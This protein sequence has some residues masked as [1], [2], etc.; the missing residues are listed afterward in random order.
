MAF[1]GLFDLEKVLDLPKER[2]PDRWATAWTLYALLYRSFQISRYAI[3]TYP[4]LL[5]LY[6]PLRVALPV[7]AYRRQYRLPFLPLLLRNH[8]RFY[9]AA[10]VRYE[11]HESSCLFPISFVRHQ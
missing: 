7:H 1:L 2:I 4:G 8:Q 10:R 6:S 9:I 5:W 11:P 3:L